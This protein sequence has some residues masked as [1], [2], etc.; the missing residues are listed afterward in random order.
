MHYAG[1]CIQRLQSLI[2]TQNP[3]QRRARRRGII[4]PRQS[5]SPL[6]SGAVRMAKVGDAA[7]AP[8]SPAQV[9]LVHR[10]PW[11]RPG[12][13]PPPRPGGPPPLRPGGP[14]PLRPGGPPPLR[15]GGPPPLRPGGPP[16]RRPG[17]PPLP[18]PGG[19]LP[20]RPGGLPPPW[21]GGPL[22]S[23]PGGPLSGT[24]G[25]PLGP[26]EPRPRIDSSGNL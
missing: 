9:F 19:P 18:W 20:R 5:S 14:P 24:V 21:P 7:S 1:R 10:R 2:W 3:F 13:P 17:G 8:L 22:P 15:P 4:A 12:G 26:F 16:P 6:R 25:S 23:R 11:A